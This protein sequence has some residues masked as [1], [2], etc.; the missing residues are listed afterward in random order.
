[1]ILTANNIKKIDL[2]K[3]YYFINITTFKLKMSLAKILD[4]SYSVPTGQKLEDLP[5]IKEWS[6]NDENQLNKDLIIQAY[7]SRDLYFNPNETTSFI[8]E[9]HIKKL[10]YNPS[11]K[12]LLSRKKNLFISYMKHLVLNEKILDES[13]KSL[14]D[15][16]VNL[17][18]N[19]IESKNKEKA[20][21]ILEMATNG[22]HPKEIYNEFTVDELNY[23]GW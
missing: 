14:Y 12:E 23:L 18:L 15:E 9:R 21:K 1:M 2:F 4:E 19:S 3:Y 8:F 10:G 20:I 5:F 13:F 22:Q 11:D 7:I 17:N 16:A 6:K